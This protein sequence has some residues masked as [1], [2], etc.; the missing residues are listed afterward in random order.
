MGRVKK[1]EREAVEAALLSAQDDLSEA[2]EQA[3]QALDA[4]RQESLTKDANRPYVVLMQQKGQPIVH[5]YGPYA[6][7][8][9]ASRAVKDLACPGPDPCYSAIQKL[10]EV[11]P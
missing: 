6:T 10:R 9:Q 1:A 8:A 2:S 7:H 11:R 5:T 4:V 3:I